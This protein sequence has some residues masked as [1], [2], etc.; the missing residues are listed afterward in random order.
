MTAP[1]E[2]RAGQHDTANAYRNH[3][4]RCPEATAANTRYRKRR[5]AGMLIPASMD[6][7]GVVRRRQALAAI[8]YGLR[9]LE[10]YFNTTS[11]GIGTYATPGRRVFRAT[12]RRWCEVY[13]LLSMTPGRNVRAKLE[14]RKRGWAP[15]LAWDDDTIDDPDAKPDLGDK[16]ARDRVDVVE[17]ARHLLGFGMSRP[18][19]AKQ[20]EVSEQYLRLLLGG[21]KRAAA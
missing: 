3:G 20:L 5:A 6:N 4:C 8:G 21:G 2:C 13:D 9:D 7:T 10:P 1:G 15:P 17:E 14:A 19:V 12:Y 16:R 18:A 11:R